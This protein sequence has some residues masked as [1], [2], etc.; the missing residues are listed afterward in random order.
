MPAW[1][2]DFA[3]GRSRLGAAL[4]TVRGRPRAAAAMAPAEV[5]ALLAA[6]RGPAAAGLDLLLLAPGAATP[7]ELQQRAEAWMQPAGDE[8]AAS[9]DVL[10]RSDRVLWRPGRAVCFGGPGAAAE[11]LPALIRFAEVEAE[12]RRL[13]ALAAEGWP[14]LEGIAP[15]LHSLDAPALAERP[16]LDAMTREFALARLDFVRL[17]AALGFPP[18]DL[19][20]LGQRLFAEL[21]MQADT[22]ERL[23]DLDDAIEV[24]ED[25]CATAN[26]RVS[27]HRHFL[28]EYRLEVAILVALATEIVL[29]LAETL[30]L[31]AGG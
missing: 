8:A 15:L 24:A 27:E 22:A 6:G 11:L 21:A 16:R 5:E 18:R 3:A 25:F 13:E 17:D 19:P 14:A 23:R 20:G 2:I 30:L 10:V 7:F 29:T 12:L 1:R 26:D 28:K 4:G 9:I 31:A